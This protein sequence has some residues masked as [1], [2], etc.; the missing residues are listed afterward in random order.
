MV[1]IIIIIIIIIGNKNNYKYVVVVIRG[2]TLF[3]RNL[4]MCIHQSVY[5]RTP[6]GVGGGGRRC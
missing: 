4:H 3:Y 1:L 6:N 2:S 5:L